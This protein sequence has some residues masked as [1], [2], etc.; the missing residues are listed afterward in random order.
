[1]IS[2]RLSSLKVH[3]R[4]HT[5][6]KPY[7]C[8]ECGKYFTQSSIHQRIHTGDKPYKCNVCGKSFTKTSNL[9]SPENQYWR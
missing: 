7:K 5:G 6:D 2:A 4:L 3:Q 9:S 8:N 1:R